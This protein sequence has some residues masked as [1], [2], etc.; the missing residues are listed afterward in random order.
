[1]LLRLEK[2]CMRARAY[3]RGYACGLDT[4]RCAEFFFTLQ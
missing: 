2:I 1:M 3:V 4:F